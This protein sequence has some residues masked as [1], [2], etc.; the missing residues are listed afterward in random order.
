MQIS[1]SDV[2][3]PALDEMSEIYRLVNAYFLYVTP[4][5]YNKQG[6]A[7]CH[8]I[9]WLTYTKASYYPSHTRSISPL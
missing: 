6:S 1:D 2:M 4:H 8:M 7:A 5:L 9:R 3:K